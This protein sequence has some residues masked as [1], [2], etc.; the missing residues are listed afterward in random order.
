MKLKRNTCN[1]AAV[2]YSLHFGERPQPNLRRVFILKDLD[3]V[4]FPQPLLQHLHSPCLLYRI[5][6]MLL[7]VRYQVWR[8]VTSVS[9]LEKVII[10]LQA[11]FLMSHLLQY[12][13]DL[14]IKR[15][16]VFLLFISV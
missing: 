10:C 3:V 4:L 1:C 15:I 7:F 16:V 12:R 8:V 9:R 11:Y 2:P 6:L 13:I 5:V 14:N